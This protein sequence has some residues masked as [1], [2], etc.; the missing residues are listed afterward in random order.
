M[1]HARVVLVWDAG[2]A[3]GRHGASFGDRKRDRCAISPDDRRREFFGHDK[4]VG[5]LYRAVKPDPAAV[6]FSE[7]VAGIATLAGAC[8]LYTFPSPRD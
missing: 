1:G 7:R 8:L 6:E 3:T 2:L 4:Y 5:T